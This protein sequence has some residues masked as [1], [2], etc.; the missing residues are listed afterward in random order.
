MISMW[1]RG[2]YVCAVLTGVSPD[3]VISRLGVTYREHDSMACKGDA[4]LTTST[5]DFN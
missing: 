1:L 4:A 2:L 3:D 5:V